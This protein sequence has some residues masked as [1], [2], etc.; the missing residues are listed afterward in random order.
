[1]RFAPLPEAVRAELEDGTRPRRDGRSGG[2]RPLERD[3][4]GLGRR[5]LRGTTGELSLGSGFEHVC[6]AVRDCWASLYTPRAMAIAQRGAATWS[7]RWASRSRLMVDAG[8]S[9]VLFTCNPVSGDPSMVAIDAS[10][11]LG[12]AVVGGDMTPDDFLVSKITGEVVR[13]TVSRRRSS[14]FPTGGSR[15]RA[16]R[17][18]AGA[19]GGALPR[20]GGA[21]GARRDGAACRTALRLAPGRRVGARPRPVAPRGARAPPGAS[22]DGTA[23]VDEALSGSALSLVMS[24]FGGTQEKRD[25]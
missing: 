13:Q 14:T 6:D 2:R 1:M 18:A 25:D 24:T 3:R 15:D 23:A 5:D 12:L 21:R 19:A 9:G 7:R 10:W 4:R 16:P 20:R 11:G 22:C 8:V 17:R